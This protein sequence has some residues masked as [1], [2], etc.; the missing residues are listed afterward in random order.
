MG[1][2]SLTPCRFR[3]FPVGKSLLQP[4][5]YFGGFAKGVNLEIKCAIDFLAVVLGLY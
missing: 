2:W 5:Y 3:V 1:F 4:S